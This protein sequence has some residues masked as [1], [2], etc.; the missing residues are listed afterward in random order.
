[1]SSKAK[2]MIVWITHN[3]LCMSYSNRRE[4]FTYLLCVRLSNIVSKSLGIT[5]KIIL[6]ITSKT[7]GIQKVFR[8]YLEIGQEADC[9]QPSEPPNISREVDIWD[10]GWLSGWKNNDQLQEKG[11]NKLYGNIPIKDCQD[12]DKVYHK[13]NPKGDV[14][15]TRRQNYQL[16]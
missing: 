2:S 1:M 13:L 7:W 5:C 8:I 11:S 3:H 12:E 14:V 16:R 10:P 9:W 15:A 6:W 4:W